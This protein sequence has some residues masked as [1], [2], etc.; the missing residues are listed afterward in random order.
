[1]SWEY[2]FLKRQLKLP[3]N[4]VLRAFEDYC[5]GS[6]QTLQRLEWSVKVRGDRTI[7][8]RFVHV[9]RITSPA[10]HER[11][12]HLLQTIGHEPRFWPID[13]KTWEQQVLQKCTDAVVGYA[14]GQER[15]IA[16]LKVYYGIVGCP[17]DLFERC[18]RPVMPDFPD[19]RPPGTP[20]VGICGIMPLDGAPKFRVYLFY[21]GLELSRRDV[22]DYLCRT[23]QIPTLPQHPR[24]GV[25]WKEEGAEDL[26]YLKLAP[27]R[28]AIRST[29]TRI[30]ARQP[31]LAQRVGQ[32]TWCALPLTH[33][34]QPSPFERLPSEATVYVDLPR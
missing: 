2:Q 32:I 27:G 23:L 31:L 5:V 7:D 12:R 11:V 21:Q 17:R 34:R 22:R 16:A 13:S 1:M 3:D 24:I 33:L 10:G 15:G 8:D 26:V 4:R 6:W 29:L 19:A 14:G 25:S 18:I 30:S 9:C 20:I 28:A